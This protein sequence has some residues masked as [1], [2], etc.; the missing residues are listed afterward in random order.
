MKFLKPREL[1]A[2][3]IQLMIVA[4]L[5]PAI[6]ILLGVINTAF[7]EVISNFCSDLASMVLSEIP[8]SDEIQSAVTGIKASG[9][10]VSLTTYATVVLE[11]LS[12][13]MVTLMYIGSWLFAFRIIFKEM[14]KMP[15]IPILQTLCGLFFGVLTYTFFGDTVMMV[16]ATLFIMTMDIVLTILFSRK[17]SWKKA[18]DLALN[19]SLQSVHAVLCISYAVVISSCFTGS[20]TN[21]THAVVSVAV[22][23]LLWIIYLVVQ[24][25]VVE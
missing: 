16:M 17:A 20:F 11:Y 10:S 4:A 1:L 6:G 23:T 22:V 15:G 13:E 18:L 12:N 5:L 21:V 14:I 8:G 24:Y 3:G 2:T 19:L 7:P 25:I 9:G